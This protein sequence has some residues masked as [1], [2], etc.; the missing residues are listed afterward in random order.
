MGKANF[1]EQAGD[2]VSIA[3]CK[4]QTYRLAQQDILFCVIEEATDLID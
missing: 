2:S 1:V 3:L 4:L